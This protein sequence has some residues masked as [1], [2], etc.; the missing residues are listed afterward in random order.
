MAAVGEN[1]KVDLWR[2]PRSLEVT[3]FDIAD[4]LAYAE[5]IDVKFVSICPVVEL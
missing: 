5:S 4:E 1:R 3:I 2:L